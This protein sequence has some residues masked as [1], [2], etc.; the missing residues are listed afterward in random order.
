MRLDTV[1][2]RLRETGLKVKRQ[3][4]HF[5][6]PE[7]RFLG[8]QV[9]TQGMS[10]DPYKISA[11]KRWPIPNTVKEPRSSLGFRSYHRRFT[12]GFSQIAGSLH[13]VVSVCVHD[14][15]QARVNLV[16]RSAWTP[17]HLLAFELLK[18][19]RISTPIQGYADFT[20]PL[21]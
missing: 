4:C 10:M 9:S 14:S 8:H 6:L 18:D 7:V 1:L 16:F 17:Q 20:I 12:E 13:D 5:L 3:K 19:K 21:T 11:V 15:S 2:K